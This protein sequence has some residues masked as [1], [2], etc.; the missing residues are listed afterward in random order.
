MS[1]ADEDGG[2]IQ[3]LLLTFFYRYMKPLIEDGRL[4][5]AMPPLYRLVVGNKEHYIWEDA[6]LKELTK[7]KSNYKISRYNKYREGH[8]M[9]AKEIL[10]M[11]AKVTEEY[12]I[13]LSNLKEYMKDIPFQITLRELMGTTVIKVFET[14]SKYHLTN[15]F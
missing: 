11:W 6:E 8:V 1:D 13:R 14:D 10:K 5:I 9:N 12:T 7:G 3:C 15:I 4:Y 2:H